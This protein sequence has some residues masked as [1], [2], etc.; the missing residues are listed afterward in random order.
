[1]KFADNYIDLGA[2]WVYGE[3][4]NSVYEMVDDVDELGKSDGTIMNRDWIRSNGKKISQ[5]VID[6]MLDLITTIYEKMEDDE[7]DPK[8]TFGEYLSK[9]FEKEVEK[10]NIR[11][12]KHLSK[13]FIVTLK[14]MEGNMADMDMSAYDYWSFKPCD[15]R[16]LLNWRDKG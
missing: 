2:Q 4:D 14:K 11:I 16:G 6:Q 7:I 1:M 15:G 5:G 13:E 8:I 12:D 9:M 10:R 3:N